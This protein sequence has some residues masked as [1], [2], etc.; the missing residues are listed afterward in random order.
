MTRLSLART[1]LALL[2]AA[3]VLPSPA[4]ASPAASTA[5]VG[6]FQ[7]RPGP[8]RPRPQS[9]QSEEDNGPPRAQERQE[10]NGPEYSDV[11]PEDAVTKPGMFDVHEVEDDLFF[12]IPVSELGKEMILIKRTVETTLQD[13]AQ[14]F[15]SGPR[16]IV[17]WE[18][19]ED[20]IILREKRY[21]LIAD[22]TAAVSRVVEGF[23]RGAIL[24]TFD[25]EV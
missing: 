10:R 18:R 23:R 15:P 19:D 16:L 14:F 9:R 17:E 24:A 22:T 25:I 11:I 13:P 6:P 7:Q 20:R 8:R 4:T 21:D 2:V 12:E 1:L 3:L 5:A